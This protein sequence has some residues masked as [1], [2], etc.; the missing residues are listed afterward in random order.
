M[1]WTIC[2]NTRC[3]HSETIRLELDDKDDEF[4]DNF[5]LN[6]CSDEKEDSDYADSDHDL[7]LSRQ[8]LLQMNE[9]HV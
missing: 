8:L 3:T 6:S 4:D 7:D 2:E 1:P 5:D 9:L